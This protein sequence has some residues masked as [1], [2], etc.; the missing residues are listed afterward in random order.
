MNCKNQS[1]PDSVSTVAHGNN[2]VNTKGMNP[3]SGEAKKPY[4]VLVHKVGSKFHKIGE[5]QK[6]TGN[7]AEIGRDS[8]CKVRYDEHFEMVNNR[9]AAIMK[10][11]NHWKLLP[12]SRTDP[13]FVN[14][15]MV[16]KEWYLQHGDEIQCAVNGPKLGFIIPSGK[17]KTAGNSSSS[18]RLNLFGKKA[19]RSY[20]RIIAV[21]ICVVLLAIGVYC[22]FSHSANTNNTVAVPEHAIIIPKQ[23]EKT[24]KWGYVYK[25]KVI[26][27]Y[28][29]DYA[30][31]FSS[32]LARIKIN[33]SWGFI[34]KT[35]QEVI[36]PKYDFADHFIEGMAKVG[37]NGK[38]GYIDN[39]GS[40][41]I[42]LIYDAIG[43]F[44]EGFAKAEL[45]KKYG[46]FDREGNEAIPIKYD[47]AEDFENG[48]AK[49]SLA[50]N[51]GRIDI[52]GI[53]TIQSKKISLLDAVKEK[54]VRFSATGNGIQSSRINIENLTDMKLHLIIPAGT[55]LSANSSS[56]QNMVLTK[57]RDI[58]VDAKKTHSGSVS[59]AC[60]NI[61]RNIPTGNDSFG[62]A[63]RPDNHLLSKL[64]RLLSQR[65]ESYAVV[66]AAIW[67]VT[68]DATYSDMG[69]LL[70][71][72]R[73][74][75]ID[76]DDYQKAVSIV[77]EARKL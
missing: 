77:N 42:P 26:V 21:L 45:N 73:Q 58:V 62:I 37:V 14:G 22:I 10:D 66:Q 43:D 13:T 7:Y 56:Y 39:T 28:I 2:G 74:R 68:D 60:M 18:R 29:Y 3:I 48:Y 40:E 32:D 53:F 75:T 76:Y 12:L 16:Q 6:I 17:M 24:G 5:E 67:I 34:D 33:E 70:N 4:I 54:Y 9:H 27:D 65:N 30:D 51:T 57:P 61:R 38:Y 35:G 31:G 36:P 11:D 52:N 20:R 23:N 64:I 72:Y 25:R 1:A 69:I 8:K 46:F 50:E 47:E 19:L 49:V 15:Q 55:F 59:V 63:K 71:Q 44:I 41:I